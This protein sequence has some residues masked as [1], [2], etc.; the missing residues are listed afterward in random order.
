MKKLMSSTKSS[1][2]TIDTDSSSDE[3][4]SNQYSWAKGINHVQQMYISLAYKRDNG[5]DSDDEVREIPADELKAL[6]KKAKRA[7]KSIGKRK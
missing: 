3:E 7:S 5:M 6:T 2:R 4:S 1:Q